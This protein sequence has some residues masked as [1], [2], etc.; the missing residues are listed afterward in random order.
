M[1]TQA[2]LATVAS[3][4]APVPSTHFGQGTGNRLIELDLGQPIRVEPEGP[5]GIDVIEPFRPDAP[6]KAPGGEAGPAP[7]TA[8][9]TGPRRVISGPVFDTALDLA[10]WELLPGSPLKASMRLGGSAG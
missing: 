8:S 7:P 6:Q 2:I 9:R 4:E 5:A 10:D 1:T 3:E